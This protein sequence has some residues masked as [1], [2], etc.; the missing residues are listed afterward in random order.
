MRV[1]RYCHAVDVCIDFL[2]LGMMNRTDGGRRERV[3]AG[4]SG[5][6]TRKRTDVRG[7]RHTTGYGKS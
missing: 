2:V 7:V 6:E 1:R 3:G 5:K 4:G